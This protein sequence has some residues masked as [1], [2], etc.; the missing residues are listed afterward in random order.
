MST[1]ARWFVGLLLL[2]ILVAGGI[3]LLHRGMYGLTIF[4]LL[5]VLLGGLASWVFRPATGGRAAALG[6]LT[7]MAALCSL[8][9]LGSEGLVCIMMTLPLASPLGALG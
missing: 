7:V 1:L 8:L 9:I 6:V 3:A 4:M 5:P 2:A